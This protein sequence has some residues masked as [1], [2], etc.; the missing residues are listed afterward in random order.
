M[1][2]AATTAYLL[3]THGSRDP[4]SQLGA[5]ALVR[6]LQAGLEQRGAGQIAAIAHASLE[7][8]P[9]PLHRQIEQFAHQVAPLGVTSLKLLPL[10][11]LPGVHV[12]EDLPAE[13]AQAQAKTAVSLLLLPHLGAE[14]ALLPV[15]KAQQAWL[16]SQ[17]QAKAPALSPNPS[18]INWV[19][20]AHGSR[21][22]GAQGAIAQLAQTLG[23]SPA[24]WVGAPSL[25]DRILALQGPAGAGT[26]VGLLS[27]FFFEG[28]I[29]DRLQAQLDELGLPPHRVLLSPPLGNFP[30][31]S[32]AVL[33][34]LH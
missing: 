12:C 34:H 26:S 16:A 5:Q 24:Y 3:I 23:A 7:L 17:L 8:G 4:R 1:T 22:P 27:Y 21:R 6:Q 31:F 28:G 25:T 19:L 10:F 14:G 11:L 18:P 15:L 13:I 32:V 33:A 20:L 9:A 30:E 29:L 2:S